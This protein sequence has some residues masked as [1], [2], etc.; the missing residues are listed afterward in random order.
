VLEKTGLKY[1]VHNSSDARGIP[2]ECNYTDAVSRCVPFRV[3]VHDA[4]GKRVWNEYR[5]VPSS[6]PPS[7]NVIHAHVAEGP[8]SELSKAIHDC[9]A[10]VH[11]MGAP[12]IATD[13]RIGTRI[14]REIA[15]GTG[16][17]GKVT[18]VEEILAKDK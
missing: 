12:R 16:N 11:A 2:Y 9:H 4:P 17:Q 5:C 15:P 1:K 3:R 14:D 7:I 6:F 13:I 8:W 10:A 18:R